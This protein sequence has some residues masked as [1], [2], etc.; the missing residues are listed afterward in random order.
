MQIDTASYYKFR[1]ILLR[2]RNRSWRT[3]VCWCNDY[4][5]ACIRIDCAVDHLLS[6]SVQHKLNSNVGAHAIRVDELVGN[7]ISE[8]SLEALLKSISV[9]C[10]ENVGIDLLEGKINI[11][12]CHDCV[13]CD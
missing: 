7:E 11:W 9:D 3:S 6:P 5:S 1:N 13:N 4:I 8:G 12:I 10:L 2:K